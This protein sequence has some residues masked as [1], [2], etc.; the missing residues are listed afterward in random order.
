VVSVESETVTVATFVR[1]TRPSTL[2]ARVVWA[3]TIPLHERI[4][5]YLLTSAARRHCA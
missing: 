5:P 1:Y 3:A 4:L 2:P